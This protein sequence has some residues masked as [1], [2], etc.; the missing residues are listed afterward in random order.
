MGRPV[1]IL[2]DTNAVLWLAF[3]PN[4][5]S[6]AARATI[7]EAQANAVPLA[8][9]DFT[10]LELATLARKG[11]LD[12]SITLESFLHQIETRFEILAISARACVRSLALPASYPNDPADRIIGATSLVEGIPLITADR[13][14]RESKVV[15]TIW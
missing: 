1:L 14:I 6:K 7:S 3:E 15:N 11:R 2:L 4:R 13:H 12:I 5:L 9:C 8:V 10:L